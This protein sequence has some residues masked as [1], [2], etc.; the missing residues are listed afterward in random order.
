[1]TG[2]EHA[3]EHAKAAATADASRRGHTL[4]GWTL[5]H[6]FPT[7]YSIA[8][9]SACGEHATVSTYEARRPGWTSTPGGYAIHQQCEAQR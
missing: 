7:R 3:H 2:P 9:C 8:C 6:H 5:K 1:M 4:G